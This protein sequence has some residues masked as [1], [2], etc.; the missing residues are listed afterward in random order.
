MESLKE[1]LTGINTTLTL[2]H[3]KQKLHDPYTNEYQELLNVEIALLNFKKDEI[4]KY[5]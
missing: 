4:N 2:L 5:L 1:T 3:Q